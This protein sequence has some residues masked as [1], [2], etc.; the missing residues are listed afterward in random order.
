MIK[1]IYVNNSCGEAFITADGIN[2]PVK[3]DINIPP[4]KSTFLSV[5]SRKIFNL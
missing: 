5:D 3:T 2:I 1:I 4:V